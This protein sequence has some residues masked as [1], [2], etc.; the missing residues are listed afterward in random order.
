M[1][2]WRQNAVETTTVAAS[3]IAAFRQR[4]GEGG[5]GPC[6]AVL[7]VINGRSGE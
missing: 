7:T 3:G 6:C 4:D 2:R 1:S 5:N